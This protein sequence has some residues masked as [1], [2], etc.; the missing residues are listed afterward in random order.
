MCE[1]SL[2]SF[3]YISTLI[4]SLG[5]RI[6]DNHDQLKQPILIYFE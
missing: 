2:G 5:I 3:V 4:D 6:C 1:L